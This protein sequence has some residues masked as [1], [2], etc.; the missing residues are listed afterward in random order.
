MLKIRKPIVNVEPIPT[1]NNQL[2]ANPY[3]TPGKIAEHLLKKPEKKK[4]SVGRPPS[5]KDE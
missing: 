4:K 3:Q 5:K 1:A 2:P